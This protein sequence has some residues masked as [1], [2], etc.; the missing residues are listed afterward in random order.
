M[1][2]VT[3][4][5]LGVLTSTGGFLDAGSISTAASAGATF[6]LSLIWPIVV[7]TLAIIL[8]VEMSGRLAAVSG[9][10][11]SEALRERFGFAFYLLPL[12]ADVISNGFLLAAEL[13]GVSIGLALLTGLDW[14]TVL[15]VS[16]L[17]VFAMVWRAPFGL[18]EDLPSILGLSALLFVVAIVVQPP[19]GD[20][21]QALA[22]KVPGSGSAQYLYLVAAILGATMSPY[23]VYF[24]SSGAREDRWSRRSLRINRMTA[25]LGNGFGS[26]S[27][28]GILVACSVVLQPRGITADSLSEV[29][30]SLA[31]PFG[32]L[33]AI[34]FGLILFAC[35]FGAALE[36]SLAV[37]YDI[38][39]GFGWEW[40]EEKKPV[41]AARFN[42]VLIIYIAVAFTL[43]FVIGDPLQLA[44]FA[45]AL[46]ALILPV[47]LAPFLILMNDADY[48]RD[49]RNGVLTNLATIAV[50]ILAFVVAAASLALLLL[51]GGGR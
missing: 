42:L 38:S 47:A 45:S 48:L 46:I 3:A 22:P 43:A 29:G 44:L 18:I 33:G 14:H 1:R 20:I 23:L 9:K 49:Q 8:L 10:A 13:G 25:V 15:P 40:G 35:C 30:L 26:L 50:V 51:T 32:Q 11:Y 21:L 4:V 6:G 16:A 7:G 27:A 28:I 36:V 39:Q 5:L 17:L 19:S 37:A 31:A 34:G 2:I 12:S 41:E 24:Y